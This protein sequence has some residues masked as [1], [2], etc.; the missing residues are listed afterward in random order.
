[1]DERQENMEPKPF[2]V[3]VTVDAPR[4]TVWAALTEPA[5]IR[6][7]F[8]W[9]YDGLAEEIQHI[10]VTH[11]DP[12]PPD[13]I[14]LEVGQE[15]QVAAE[16]GRTVLRAI[17]PGALDGELAGTY[18]PLEEGWRSFFEQLRYLLERRP[19]TPRRTLRLT[20]TATGEQLLAV[21]DG[22]GAK[23]EWHA[24]THQRMVVDTDGRLLVAAAEVPLTDPESGPISLVVNAYGVDDAELQRLAG[25]WSRRWRAEVPDG[26]LDRPGP[27]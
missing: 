5:R 14:A 20:G 25:E 26:K 27:T 11:A 7:W 9:E 1:M 19:G 24:G 8:G 22:A 3:E 23:E 17:S 4:E 21:L 15:I 10:F 6:Q 16:G 12:F 18:D 13:R 2:R